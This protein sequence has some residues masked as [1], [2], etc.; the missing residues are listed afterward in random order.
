MLIIDW[1][2]LSEVEQGSFYPSGQLLPTLPSSSSQTKAAEVFLSSYYYYTTDPLETDAGDKTGVADGSYVP[3]LST[4]GIE[5]G[6]IDRKKTA[7]ELKAIRVS[8]M[9]LVLLFLFGCN[10][11]EGTWEYKLLLACWS[12]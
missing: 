2:V 6:G 12:S 4:T 7:K 9:R 3:G 8:G 10:A 1:K 5:L 11:E